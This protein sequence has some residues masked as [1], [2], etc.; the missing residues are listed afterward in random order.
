MIAGLL[1]K[2]GFFETLALKGRNQA[3]HKALYG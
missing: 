2:P 3:E 1:P